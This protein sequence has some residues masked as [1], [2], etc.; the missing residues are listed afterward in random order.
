MPHAIQHGDTYTIYGPG[1]HVAGVYRATTPLDDSPESL[2]EARETD[3]ALRDH[4][5]RLLA[6]YEPAIADAL[7]AGD[8]DAAES[9]RHAVER[10]A[11]AQ[12][13]LDTLTETARRLDAN[14]PLLRRLL[15]GGRDRRTVS[16]WRSGEQLVPVAAVDYLGRV[17]SVEIVPSSDFPGQ[18][19]LRIELVL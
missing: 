13:A 15:Y 16:R 12:L 18:R 17:Q 7:A 9:I 11:G 2:T 5:L 19:R 10:S 1:D 8:T 3:A 6:R 4:W 14:R